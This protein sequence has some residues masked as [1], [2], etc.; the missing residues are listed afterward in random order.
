MPTVT[1]YN[2]I[3]ISRM[4]LHAAKELTVL[5][6]WPHTEALCPEEMA[7]P[8]EQ[9]CEHRLAVK[10]AEITA[11]NHLNTSFKISTLFIVTS[12][13]P[14]TAE[15]GFYKWS[16]DKCRLGFEFYIVAADATR[17]MLSIPSAAIGSIVAYLSIALATPNT[18]GTVTRSLKNA[19][20]PGRL[21]D[22]HYQQQARATTTRG[23]VRHC[24][25]LPNEILFTSSH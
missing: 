12:H 11:P 4:G 6:H 13:S 19:V 20:T 23:F 18:L 8:P 2:V 22:A 25:K 5:P 7:F 24:E 15:E 10:A 16:K 1:S 21:C 9:T 17:A 3:L 14:L